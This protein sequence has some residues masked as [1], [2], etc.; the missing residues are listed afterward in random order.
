M[1]DLVPGLLLDG[2]FC[3]VK[4]LGHGG[5]GVVW[6]ARDELLGRDV[7]LKRLFSA[8]DV[9]GDR[10]VLREAR[11]LAAV[12]HPGIV[13]VYD[14]IEGPPAL[15]VMDLVD[16]RSLRK[17]LD[18]RL[19]SVDEVAA[20]GL[21]LLEALAY[22][23][24]TGVAWR[25]LKPDNIIIR[26]ARV[27]LTAADVRLIDFG[28]AAP[29]V[30]DEGP[31]PAITATVT[32]SIRGTAAYLAPEL[33][34]P[35]GKPDPAA[36]DRYAL[37]VVLLE[38]LL[39]DNPF[40]AP[41]I[42]QTLARHVEREP[43]SPIDA[44]APGEVSPA[45][46]AAV[47]GLLHKEPHKRASLDDLRKALSSSIPPPPPSPPAS[48]VP[49]E[50]STTTKRGGVA[51]LA[52][53]CIAIIVLAT[54]PTAMQTA[55]QTTTTTTTTTPAIAAPLPL[56]VP[57]P[58]STSPPQ[59]PSPEELERGETRTGAPVV[60]RRRP[61]LAVVTPTP[62]GLPAK[63]ALLAEPRCA[64]L[65]CSSLA[66]AAVPVDLVTLQRYRADVD[67]CVTRCLAP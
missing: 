10:R 13:T 49:L 57:P 55:A 3:L 14:V 60:V 19:L 63:R 27:P 4:P 36:A 1:V 11:A 61:A 6:R 26:F 64:A 25:D 9:D 21:G 40:R 43:P 5:T 44:R 35:T 67:V 46:A 22:A 47:L 32:T 41:T 54:R 29:V 8:G 39:G 52:L 15:L 51:F 58:S 38:A 48:P 65:P 16:G 56:L 28:L 37:G 45:M 12:R 24:A 2:R 7:A 30:V 33:L 23:H 50:R 17:I 34:E 53:A 20:L 62:V 66:A 18:E 59:P 31:A 42:A